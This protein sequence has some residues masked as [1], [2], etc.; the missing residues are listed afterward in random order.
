LSEHTQADNETS[1]TFADGSLPDHCFAFVPDSATPSTRKLKLCGP[2][3]KPSAA[4]V[5]AAKAALGKG[6][7]GN[8]VQLPSSARSG[9]IAKVNAAAKS[10]GIDP[11][12]A[13]EIDPLAFDDPTSSDV[14]TD[15][16]MGAV[17]PAGALNRMRTRLKGK[18]RHGRTLTADDIDEA[19]KH[20]A[21]HAL[22]KLP[23]DNTGAASA[24]ED[25]S[26]TAKDDGDDFAKLAKADPRVLY[27]MASATNPTDDGD[28][29]I[30]AC[31]ECQFYQWG[32]CQLVEGTIE[33][34]H[35]CSLFCD[36]PVTF[37]S[38]DD[39]E[40]GEDDEPDEMP[41]AYVEKLF[42][43]AELKPFAEPPAW[44]QYFPTPG[45]YTHPSYGKVDLPPERIA[46][47]VDQFNAGIYQKHIPIDAE[48][49]TKLS[50]ATGYIKE[51]RVASDGSAEARVEWTDR[52]EKLIRG[53]RMLSFSPEWYDEWT[54]PV[55]E[56]VY[57]DVAIGGALTTR[58]FF[59][60]RALR[61][62]AASEV[63]AIVWADEDAAETITPQPRQGAKPMAEEQKTASTGL[64]V[65]MTEAQF[66]K[67]FAELETRYAT[68]LAAAKTAA[69]ET[70]TKL[71]GELAIEQ[72]ARAK[73]EGDASTKRF[74]D[75][76]RGR[77]DANGNAWVGDIKAKVAH[78][79]HLAKTAGEDS[80][81]FKAYVA[82]QRATAEQVKDSGLFKVFGSDAAGDGGASVAPFDALMGQARAYAE[83]HPE[84]TP[85]RAFAEITI[86]DPKNR[87]L[88]RKL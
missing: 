36:Q 4:I 49:Q 66:E 57:R 5:G 16:P 28:G 43:F 18:M 86:N 56:K 9:V 53:D 29:D 13:S 77:S 19:H 25:G 62:L 17:G 60:E 1:Q 70:A 55:D 47:F 45:A 23:A 15:A 22:V 76:V 50:G 14:H 79:D 71:A 27:R 21:K 46:N 44:I 8:R 40:S 10:V 54:D 84:Y 75:E 67:R 87:D 20:A 82:D 31:G 34:D 30:D 52:G 24:S 6:Y 26:F 59:K 38:Q 73:A 33:A 37:V 41:M 65:A 72:T 61:P 58:P 78:L 35:V 39:L 51:M 88:V 80:D 11:F 12:S 64:P 69:E 81:V 42:A 83:A 74:T 68:E 2:D 63:G 7:R 3:G 85:E 32:R 48:H